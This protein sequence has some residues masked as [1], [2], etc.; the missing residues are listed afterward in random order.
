MSAPEQSDVAAAVR[1]DA[2]PASDK[3]RD[4]GDEIAQVERRMAIRREQLKRHAGE[5]TVEARR[6]V[7]PLPIV[8]LVVLAGAGFVVAHLLRR[9]EAPPRYLYD[10]RYRYRYREPY[11]Y[12]DRPRKAGAAGKIAAVAATAIRLGMSPQLRFV[13]NAIARRRRRHER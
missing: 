1:R 13:W 8:G 5:A 11:V 3:K 2:V 9:R 6:K 4:V 7:R 12:R 10:D